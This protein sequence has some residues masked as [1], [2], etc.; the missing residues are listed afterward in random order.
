MLK[1]IDLNHVEH[2]VHLRNI[3][4]VVLQTLNNEHRATFHFIGP[5]VLPVQVDLNTFNRIKSALEK[6]DAQ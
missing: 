4:N 5:H 3:N 6:Y 1:F 2:V